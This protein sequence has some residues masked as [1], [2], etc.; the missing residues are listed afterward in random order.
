MP[1]DPEKYREK[2]EKVLGIRRRGIPFQAIAVVFTFVIL[3]GFAVLVLPKVIASFQERNLDDA[4]YRLKDERPWSATLGPEI[5]GL[6]GVECVVLDKNDTRLIVTFDREKTG[7]AA[8]EAL[9]RAKGLEAILL[10]R[11]PHITRKEIM[12]EEAER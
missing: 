4:I 1:Y 7:T 10:N 12:K 5:A 6:G 3:L 2:R 11:V 9:F 8:V